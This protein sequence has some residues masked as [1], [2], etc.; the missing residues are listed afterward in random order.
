LIFLGNVILISGPV[1]YRDL[2]RYLFMAWKSYVMI[3]T[4]DTV[5]VPMIFQAISGKS[6]KY[7]IDCF[8]ANGD[9]FFSPYL[10]PSKIVYYLRPEMQ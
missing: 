10:I 4:F 7:S 1:F 6:S 2:E 5:H 8:Y 9:N 3:D